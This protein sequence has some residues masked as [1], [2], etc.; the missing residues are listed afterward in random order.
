VR[1]APPPS[2]A[3]D[4]LDDDA[5]QSDG[6]PC[7]GG[8]LVRSGS[9]FVCDCS[10]AAQAGP[11]C[12]G[13]PALDDDADTVDPME[14]VLSVS[15]S[16]YTTCAAMESRTVRCWAETTT[17]TWVTAPAPPLPSPCA[18]QRLSQVQQLDVGLLNACAVIDDGTYVVGVR[19]PA[20]CCTTAATTIARSP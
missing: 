4:E 13:E 17:E 9:V 16:N 14:R 7:H 18:C 15:T 2:A 3:G 20:T 6:D 8:V 19:T 12:D 5:G 11:L 10:S 1:D